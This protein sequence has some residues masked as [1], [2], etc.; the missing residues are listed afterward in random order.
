M[1]EQ[2]TSDELLDQ[3]AVWA[4]KIPEAGP[5]RM[6][7]LKRP[8]INVSTA[9]QTHIDYHRTHEIAAQEVKAVASERFHHDSARYL[10]KI[11]DGKPPGDYT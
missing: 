2:T 10:Q 6:L 8:T 1:S 9:L 4:N 7:L 11:K 3:I 5:I